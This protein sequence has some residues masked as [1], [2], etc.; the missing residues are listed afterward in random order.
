[1]ELGILMFYTICIQIVNGS[2]TFG[3]DDEYID[4][5]HIMNLYF[6]VEKVA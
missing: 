5:D 3:K 6:N 2:I 1:M 4:K